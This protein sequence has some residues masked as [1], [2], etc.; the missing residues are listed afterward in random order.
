MKTPIFKDPVSRMY[1]QSRQKF[2]T[3]SALAKRGSAGLRGLGELR[4]LGQ[5]VTKDDMLQH[6]LKLI[7]ERHVT[8]A[9]A[10]QV[11]S[12]LP[13]EGPALAEWVRNQ[14]DTMAGHMQQIGQAH[15]QARQ[16]LANHSLNAMLSAIGSGGQNG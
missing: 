10:A 4:A 3:L 13:K 11:L 15:E 5:K 9:E 12:S 7:Q 6:T 8:S 2:D 1:L 16:D 14:H